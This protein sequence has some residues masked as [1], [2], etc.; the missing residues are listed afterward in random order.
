M[1]AQWGVG[2]SQSLAGHLKMLLTDYIEDQ[3]SLTD[4]D[5]YIISALYICITRLKSL[6]EINIQFIL[7]I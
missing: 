2:R 7:E 6:I 3:R 5:C 1:H 4:R